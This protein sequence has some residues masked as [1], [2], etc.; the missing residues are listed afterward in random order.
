MR[1]AAEHDGQQKYYADEIHRTTTSQPLHL[2]LIFN[3]PTLRA[4]PKCH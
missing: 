1:G 2:A 4:H 3:S